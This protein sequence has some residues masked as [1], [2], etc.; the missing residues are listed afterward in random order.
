M[1]NRAMFLIIVAAGIV[2]GA[3]LGVAV[4]AVLPSTW[5]KPANQKGI[6]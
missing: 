3:V 1:S 2:V 6:S 5:R 4:A